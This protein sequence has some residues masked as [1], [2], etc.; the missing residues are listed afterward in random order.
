[1]TDLTREQLDAIGRIPSCA[2]ANAIETFDIQYRDE[3]FMLPQVRSI[4][5]DLG[6]MIGYAVT[7]VITASAPPSP[8]MRIARCLFPSRA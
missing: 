5:P 8:H 1:M 2:I 4:F 3:G 6:N 7:G